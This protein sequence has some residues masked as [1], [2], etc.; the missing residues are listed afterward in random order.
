MT[1][2]SSF[3]R[4]PQSSQINLSL[5]RNDGARSAFTRPSAIKKRSAFTRLSALLKDT[6]PSFFPIFD[7]GGEAVIG[8][9]VLIE[10]FNHI[11]WAGDDIGA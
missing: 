11:R 7:K 1:K 3:Y 10:L 2:Q 5:L 4:L 6:L 8:K 9:R